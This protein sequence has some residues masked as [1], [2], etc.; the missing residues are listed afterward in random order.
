MRSNRAALV[1]IALGLATAPAHAGFRISAWS[2]DTFTVP[3]RQAELELWITQVVQ[4]ED[5]ATGTTAVL[6]APVIGVTDQLELAIPLTAEY[7]RMAN[8]TQLTSWGIDARYRILAPRPGQKLAPLIRAGA[9]RIVATDD[10]FR[11]AADLVLGIDPMPRLHIVLNAGVSTL[12]KP[13]TIVAEYS[14]GIFYAVTS[15]IRL[16]VDAFGNQEISAP[17]P[18]DGWFAAGPGISLS[19]GRF[20]V[21]ASVPFGITAK[22]PDAMPRVIWALAF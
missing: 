11:L 16:G 22:A 2:F 13:K 12:T 1:L 14:A 8:A 5:G 10:A 15:D 19:H 4:G 9:R 20:W 17:G 3:E 21:A 7:S 6:L 18:T